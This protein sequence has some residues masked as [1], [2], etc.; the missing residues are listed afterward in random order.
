MG[1]YSLTTTLKNIKTDILNNPDKYDNY[2]INNLSNAYNRWPGNA[3]SMVTQQFMGGSLP[4]LYKY[5][6]EYSNRYYTYA[7]LEK[8]WTKDLTYYADGTKLIAIRDEWNLRSKIYSFS[9]DRKILFIW[10]ITNPEK[11][12]YYK[13]VDPER[14]KTNLDFLN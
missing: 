10:D 5:Y 2:A 14:L 3:T 1:L 8:K 9:T 11:K 7:K 4:S 13:L 6:Q 12:L